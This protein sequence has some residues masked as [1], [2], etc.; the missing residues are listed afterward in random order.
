MAKAGARLAVLGAGPI[1]LEAAL[2]ARKLGLNVTIYERGRIGEN[3]E[4]WGFV[5]LFTPFES[6]STELGRSIVR[7]EAKGHDL[8]GE[9]DI[10]TGREHVAAYLQPLAASS[11]LIGAIKT[12]QQVV[13]VSR[14][15]QLKSD[16]P[17]DAPFR[18]L[19]RDGK[20]NESYADADAVLDCT[21]T[22]G[23]PR[24]L[25]DGGLPALG[26]LAARPQIAGGL[27]DILGGQ[28]NK[29]SGKTVLVI[30]AGYTAAT[31]VD[32]LAQL[33]KQAPETWVVWLA[34]GPRSTPMPRLANDPFKE[35]DRLAVRAN[36]LATRGEGNIEFHPSSTIES[37]V[38]LGPDKGFQV[39][40]RLVGIRKMLDVDRII[41][42]V[43][44]RP[45]FSIYREL[46]VAECPLHEGP[47]DAAV[48]TTEPS[49]FILGAKSKGRN[50]QFLL[51]DGFAQI[52]TALAKIT[53]KPIPEKL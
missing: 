42:S 6:N 29:Y 28:M 43:G 39:T 30:G 11:Y 23:N 33:A 25:G 44:Y 14:V 16:C 53:G 27:E 22:Y 12:E 45:D 1:G 26:E 2:L 47:A 19:L 50:S 3:L 52:R 17:R 51:K 20:G 9:Q 31:H 5:K 24:H 7:S 49:F 40:E 48:V 32:L 34:R 15:G 4:R 8:P 36:S 10:L 37:I 41:A 13:A 18:M 46:Q 35:R 21:G 38:S